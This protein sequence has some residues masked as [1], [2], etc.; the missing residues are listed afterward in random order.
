[1]AL[2]E[3][4]SAVAARVAHP[5]TRPPSGRRD[6]GGERR[7]APPRVPGAIAVSGRHGRGRGHPGGTR[8]V[9]AEALPVPLR[10]PEGRAGPADALLPVAGRVP[11]ARGRGAADSAGGGRVVSPSRPLPRRPAI[12]SRPARGRG[13]G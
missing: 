3:S 13:R 11:P 2:R 5:P 9:A 8:P 7:F 12:A 6:R 4:P 10:M 1:A